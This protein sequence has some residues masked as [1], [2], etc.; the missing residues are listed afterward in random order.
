MNLTIRVAVAAAAGL[1]AAGCGTTSGPSSASHP[2]TPHSPAPS[3][4]APA[5][6]APTLAPTPAP[7]GYQPLFP[8]GSMADAQAWEAS[9]AAGGHQPWHL[10]ADQTALAFTQ[11]YLGFSQINKV[12]AHTISGGDAR[13][14]VG[15]TLPNGQLN[16]AAIIHL[17]KFG[18]GRYAPWEVVGT[19]DTTLTL[20]IPA[21][22][23][24]ATSPVRIGGKITGVDENLR[25]EVHQLGASGPVGSYCCQAAG[26]QATPWSLTV[27][28]HAASG[29]VITIVV[30]T[31][32]HVVAVE[33][34]AVTGVQAG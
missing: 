29:Q 16:R 32:G 2:A 7:F 14:T 9:Y 23:S 13:V 31:G 12:A 28:F 24:T 19:D 34:F 3:S 17:V 6:P 11:G 33:R 30:H 10:S 18:S 20:D 5:T 27:P 4:S 26:G 21:Y 1:L 8:F 25:S 22:G 15:L